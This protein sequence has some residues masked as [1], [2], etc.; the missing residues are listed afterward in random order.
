[1]RASA[2]TTGDAFFA[3]I[4]MVFAT[5]AYTDGVYG[6]EE[7]AAPSVREA[8]FNPY[9]H[10]NGV[11]R[12]TDRNF[13]SK[14][15]RSDHLTLVEFWA[16]WCRPCRMLAPTINELAAE[17]EGK[18]NVGKIDIEKHRNVYFRYDVEAIPTILFFKD[19]RLVFRTVGVRD[20]DELRKIIEA[21]L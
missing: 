8:S 4:L 11:E 3:F 14:V 5:F 15:M 7:A 10:A 19:G 6:Q 12:I 2:K 13:N 17:Y 16:D 21:N 18:L 1:M 9:P 20:K